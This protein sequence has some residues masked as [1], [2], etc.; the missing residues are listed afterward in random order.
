[1]YYI[2]VLQYVLSGGGIITKRMGRPFS[3][4]PKDVRLSIRLDQ[5][6]SE[7]LNEYAEKHNVNR[8]EA[9]RRGI[10]KL[11]EEE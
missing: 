1:M 11:L 4:N 3:E 10:V 5:K 8:N 2:I 6:H 7:M 9:I